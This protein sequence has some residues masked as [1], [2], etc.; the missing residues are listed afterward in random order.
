MTDQEIDEFIVWH[1][2]QEQGEIAR[3]MKDLTAISSEAAIV[4]CLEA[5]KIHSWEDGRIEL[6]FRYLDAVEQDDT[7]ARVSAVL[8][9]EAKTP[10]AIKCW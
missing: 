7:R 9:L 3:V 1:R 6:I 2:K 5:Y 8:A 10:D 4:R